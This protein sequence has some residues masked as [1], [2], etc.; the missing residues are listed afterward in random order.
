MEMF[1][2]TNPFLLRRFEIF[3]EPPDFYIAGDTVYCIL[4]IH[5][6]A[7]IKSKNVTITAFGEV[8]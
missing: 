4:M 7:I 5:F 6:E 1:K 8:Y 2:L 3:I